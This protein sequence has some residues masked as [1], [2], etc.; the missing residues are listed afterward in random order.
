MTRSGT[1]QGSIRLVDP[2]NLLIVVNCDSFLPLFTEGK[3]K[4]LSS[5][6]ANKLGKHKRIRACSLVDLFT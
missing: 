5:I 4:L 6:N 1:E 3:K 2:L